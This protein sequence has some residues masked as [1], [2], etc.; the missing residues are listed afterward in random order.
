MHPVVFMGARQTPGDEVISS[1]QPLELPD[2]RSIAKIQVSEGQ[3]IWINIPGYNR[4]PSIYSDS[5]GRGPRTCI[6]GNV[7]LTLL[8]CAL[9]FLGVGTRDS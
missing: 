9:A 3:N 1:P 7:L 5:F 8:L 6:G 4:L 2:G